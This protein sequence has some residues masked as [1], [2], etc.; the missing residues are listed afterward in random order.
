MSLV[1]VVVATYKRKRELVN[2]LESLANQSY[3]DME[4][5]LVD[6]NGN[7]EWN[8]EVRKIVKSF[9]VKYSNINLK[10]ITNASNQGSAKTRNIGIAGSTGKYITFLD[11]DDVYLSS[12]I[13]NQVEFME[14]GQYDYS[15]TDLVLYNENDKA[16]DKRVRSY[17]KQTDVESLRLYNLKYHMTGTD[18]MMFRKEYL[19]KIDG[20]ASIN[21]G[22]EFYLMQRAIE[23]GGRFG[24]LPIC[25]IK[26]Y[27]HFGESGMSSGDGKI[28]GENA[29]YEYKK[30]F[31]NRLK[32]KDVRY[33]SM[34]HY[35][36]IAYAELRRK[37]Y[38]KFIHFAARSFLCAP[39]M[40][41]EM[42]L[43][44]K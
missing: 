22:D 1:S 23:G 27:V 38:F 41:I 37:K 4:I 14:R 16:I 36:V 18:S 9:Q 19:S 5:V 2:A 6:D 15:I 35:A 32:S 13:K 25:D 24:Y 20:F 28:S 7:D 29:L 30:T 34:R 26:A 39:I 44:R 17:I 21:L 3:A 10:L 43:T 12:K 8:E 11:D 33:I 31:F 42:F 40:C